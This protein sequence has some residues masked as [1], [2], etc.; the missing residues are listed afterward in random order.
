MVR[1][2]SIY[3]YFFGLPNKDLEIIEKVKQQRHLVHKQIN[4]SNIKLNPTTTVVKTGFYELDKQ[5]VNLSDSQIFKMATKISIP[6][7]NFKQKRKRFM[8]KKTKKH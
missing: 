8:T 1:M 5:K 6:N 4:L 3:H 2:S 7:E